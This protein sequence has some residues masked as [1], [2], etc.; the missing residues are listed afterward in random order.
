MR[1]E[2]LV[3]LRR[4]ERAELYR[5]YDTDNDIEVCVKVI[6]N[7]WIDAPLAS[8]R[9]LREAAALQSIDDD[10]VVKAVAAMP[11]FDGRP[12]LIMPWLNGESLAQRLRRDRVLKLEVA[13]SIAL[14]VGR[15]LRAVHQK[16][17]V[18][19]DVKPSNVFLRVAE[20]GDLQAVL[21]D[22]GMA[23]PIELSSADRITAPGTLLGTPAYMPPEQAFG[24]PVDQRADIYSLGALLYRMLSGRPPHA[25]RDLKD[26]VLRATTRSPRR[27]YRILQN[28]YQ[29]AV[30]RVIDRAMHRDRDDRYHSAQD[31]VAALLQAVESSA[32]R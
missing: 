25:G 24:Q 3:P 30:A 29:T 13:V 26:L 9:F 1:F 19:R 11:F 5:A 4:D 31:F 14:D 12:C 15:A 20:T 18:H 8:T 22:F 7:R 10:R 27:A 32:V 16:G 21:L 2:Q 6:G 28:P 23:G 17:F